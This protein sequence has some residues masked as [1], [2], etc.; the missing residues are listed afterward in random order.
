MYKCPM[1]NKNY[2]NEDEDAC[3]D[4]HIE[5]E[6]EKRDLNQRLDD[7]LYSSID[8]DTMSDLLHGPIKGGRK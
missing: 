3:I 7:E 4:C 1:C 8:W 5:M 2:I 6:D